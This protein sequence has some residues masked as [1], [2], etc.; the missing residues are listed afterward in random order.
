MSC[1]WQTPFPRSGPVPGRQS[2]AK[3]AADE[4]DLILFRFERQRPGPLE[5]RF[6]QPPDAPIGVAE[7][8]VDDR[9]L[10]TQLDGPF[11]VPD[12]ALEIA[13]AIERPAQRVDDIAVTR[14]QLDGAFDHVPGALQVDPLVDP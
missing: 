10:R 9:V 3:L 2:V 4:V 5:P 11:E 7:M 14:A 8:V 1:C 12:G 13:H 6:A